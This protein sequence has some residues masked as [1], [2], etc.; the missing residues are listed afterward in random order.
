[1]WNKKKKIILKTKLIFHS[2]RFVLSACV[3]KLYISIFIWDYIPVGAATCLCVYTEEIFIFVI[4]SIIVANTFL[5]HFFLKYLSGD[6][7]FFINHIQIFEIFLVPFKRNNI[8]IV[9]SKIYFLQF[10]NNSILRYSSMGWAYGE[11]E[12]NR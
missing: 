6:I 8:S 4:F 3:C 9:S 10:W 2:F 1:M 11:S 5:L 7:S 12:V